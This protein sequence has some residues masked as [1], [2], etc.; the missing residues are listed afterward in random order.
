M[1]LRPRNPRRTT[2]K[3]AA[4]RTGFKQTRNV[5]RKTDRSQSETEAP[6]DDQ[7]L[8]LGATGGLLGRGPF[9]RRGAP[10]GT[11]FELSQ[12][13]AA[14]DY[15]D[16]EFRTSPARGDEEHPPAQSNES[17]R[18]GDGLDIQ[19][20]LTLMTKRLSSLSAAADRVVNCLLEE[21]SEC[22]YDAHRAFFRALCASYPSHMAGSPFVEWHSLGE[23]GLPLAISMAKANLVTA[24]DEI[25]REQTTVS[26]LQQIAFFLKALDAACPELLVAPGRAPMPPSMVLD[27]RTCYFVEVLA[28][29]NGRSTPEAVVA[30]TFCRG[31]ARLEGPYRSL[32]GVDEEDEAL[33]SSRISDIMANIAQGHASDGD[34]GLTMLRQR[35]PRVQLAD[36]FREWIVQELHDLGAKVRPPAAPE[37]EEAGSGS[38]SD[39]EP[40]EIIRTENGPPLYS[41]AASL[42]FFVRRYKAINDEDEDDDEDDDDDDDDNSDDFEA[43]ARNQD[44]N[45]ASPSWARRRPAR[46]LPTGQSSQ[47]VYRASR[48]P[49]DREAQYTKRVRWSDHDTRVLNQC[50]KD[51]HANYADIERNDADKFE[52]A[53]NQQA[54]RDKARNLKVDYLKTDQPLPECYDL[55]SLGHKE[56][57][58]IEANGKNPHRRESDIDDEGRP[59]N[60]QLR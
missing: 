47:Q 14:S 31:P 43:D 39:A 29:N 22:L 12:V 13:N 40:Q 5:R 51:R 46:P 57:K 58:Q 4:T 49:A 50:I 6:E 1:E 48:P 16:D 34:M 18:S 42:R 60:T 21:D 26:C 52:H 30:Q 7:E 15:E 24:L 11:D 36:K 19:Q 37:I 41:D 54:Y 38:E 3:R 44:E 10:S 8:S 33:C 25:L 27:I 35:F 45:V 56:V 53:R 28:I 9:P 17:H 20:R 2:V 32:G 23:A 59:V 55:V